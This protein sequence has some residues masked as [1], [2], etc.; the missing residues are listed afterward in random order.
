[1]PQCNFLMH[2]AYYGK[3]CIE[4]ALEI[5]YL[6]IKMYLVWVIF[7]QSLCISA[8]RLTCGVTCRAR[9]CL[10][11]YT[12]TPV[13][14]SHMLTT[15]Y[16]S[17]PFKRRLTK[18]FQWNYNLFFP[19]NIHAGPGAALFPLLVAYKWDIMI[20]LMKEDELQ[21][22]LKFQSQSLGRIRRVCHIFDK[23]RK[24]SCPHRLHTQSQT[25]MS[26]KWAIIPKS[27]H[28]VSDF[29]TINVRKWDHPACLQKHAT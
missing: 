29:Y 6:Y 10:R 2:S 20:Y 5:M 9:W 12:C 15:V 21:G 23:G 28:F 26:M 8:V 16:L 1:M 14:P 27:F 13:T 18:A 24:M 11:V 17:N 7:L 19:W 25:N 3:Y 4:K 22:E